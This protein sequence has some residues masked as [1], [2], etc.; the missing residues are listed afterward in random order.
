MFGRGHKTFF[1]DLQSLLSL[2]TERDRKRCKS[3]TLNAHLFYFTGLFTAYRIETIARRHLTEGPSIYL[4]VSKLKTLAIVAL[5]E[6]M[7]T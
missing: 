1:L 7:F 2:T 3:D 5:A 6:T 4:S